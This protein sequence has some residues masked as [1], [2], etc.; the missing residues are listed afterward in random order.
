[1]SVTDSCVD[2]CVVLEGRKTVTHPS[3]NKG[4]CFER[5]LVNQA[6]DSGLEAKRAYGSNGEALGFHATVDLV[7]EGQKL[8]AKRRKAIPAWLGLSEHVDAVVVRADY[9]EALVLISWFDYLDYLK[10]KKN[11][12]GRQS[13]KP[14]ENSNYACKEETK[15]DR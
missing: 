8:Q 12:C 10:W 15:R 2:V 14:N 5:E 3:K 4:N 7:V 1:M 6:I 9:K 11:G 13:D